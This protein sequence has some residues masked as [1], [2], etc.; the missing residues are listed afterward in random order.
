M[1]DNIGK[2]IKT[3]SKIICY[4][5]TF[6]CILGGIAIA[7]IDSDL[8]WLGALII[9]VGS[10][11]S[12][13]GSYALYGF[14]QLIENSDIIAQQLR[15][16]EK[17]D[18][19]NNNVK[20]VSVCNQDSTAINVYCP[21]CNEFLTFTKEEMISSKFLECSRCGHVFNALDVLKKK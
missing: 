4:V 16:A 15:N 14:G 5:E 6:A 10:I 2:R 9:I 18:L 3:L 8:L 20:K 13:V 12:N 11:L 21:K 17:R 19:A 1:Y 7:I